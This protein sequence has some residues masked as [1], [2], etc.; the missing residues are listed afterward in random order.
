MEMQKASKGVFVTPPPLRAKNHF[1]SPDL[2]DCYGVMLPEGTRA[3]AYWLAQIAFSKPPAL[4]RGLMKLRDM[5]VSPFGVKTSEEIKHH[6]SNLDHIAF[7]PVIHSS[8]DEVELGMLDSHLDFRAWFTLDATDA[9][10]ML[11]STTS[12]KVNS[13]FGRIYLFVI[14]PFHVA[15]VRS[16]LRRVV[17]RS[18]DP[19]WQPGAKNLPTI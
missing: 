11:R 6:D 17:S 7:F 19:D 18:G 15:V 5:I 12:V 13:W 10:M 3:D 4:F 8:P 9:G 14:T 2:I 16:A 1:S